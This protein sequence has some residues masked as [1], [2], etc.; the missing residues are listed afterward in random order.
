M[1]RHCNKKHVT[2]IVVLKHLNITVLL[3]VFLINN[4]KVSAVTGESCQQIYMWEPRIGQRCVTDNEIY[5]NHTT[6]P[7][8]H[9]MWHCLRNIS[10]KVINYNMVESY[11]RLGHQPCVSL[12]PERNFVTI[13]IT[14]QEPC[15]TWVRQDAFPPPLDNI[16]H[17]VSYTVQPDGSQPDK[18]IVIARAILD[19]AKIP[20]KVHMPKNLGQFA[21]NG[22]VSDF[23]PGNYEMLTVF[24]RCNISW[25][26]YDP[27]SINSFP[28]G[29]V[30]AGYQNGRPLYVARKG[31]THSGQ[32]YRYAA[33]YYDNISME[34]AVTY[35]TDVFTFSEMEI[36]VVHG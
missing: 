30:I 31:D 11:C 10:C 19:S 18:K 36:F 26:N 27:N 2:M 20:G 9:C 34:G 12:E 16:S 33:G 22:Q 17:T 1:C 32:S 8:E 21:M 6:I 23:S 13:L 15:V 4:M 3:I 25:V 28:D 29:A 24:P 14:M 7:Q 35:G 5:E